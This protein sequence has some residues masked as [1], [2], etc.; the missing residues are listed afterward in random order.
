MTLVPILGFLEGYELVIVALVIL[1]LFGSAKLPQLARSIGQAQKEFKKG[2]ADNDEDEN[3]LSDSKKSDV[4]DT[5]KSDN[6]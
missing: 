5:T 4:A 3:K 2:L 6:I 1:V